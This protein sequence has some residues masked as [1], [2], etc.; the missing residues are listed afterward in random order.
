MVA[1]IPDQQRALLVSKAFMLAGAAQIELDQANSNLILRLRDR[2]YQ[3]CILENNPGLERMIG[4][5]RQSI[6]RYVPV[7]V[8]LDTIHPDEVEA[9]YLK[10]ADL[11]IP[12]ATLNKTSAV[13]ALWTIRSML[14]IIGTLR[15]GP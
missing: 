14:E 2:T 15:T 11:V 10:G 13:N 1:F 5:V 3:A 7:I 6:A 9:A 4:Q 12:V 8:L